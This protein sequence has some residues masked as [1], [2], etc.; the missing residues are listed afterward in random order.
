MGRLEDD[1]KGARAKLN[2]DPAIEDFAEFARKFV[3]NILHGGMRPIE[4]LGL[5][6]ATLEKYYAAAVKQYQSGQF[7]GAIKVLRVICTLCPSEFKFA[8]ALAA[9]NHRAQKW[10]E[11]VAG[12]QA[13]SLADPTDPLPYYHTADCM[14]KLGYNAA[15]AESLRIA[16]ENCTAGQAHA[17]I[18]DRAVLALKSLE[19]ARASAAAAEKNDKKPAKKAA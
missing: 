7:E 19:Q 8:F 18:K 9:C 1:I 3:K 12:Y 11:A 4:A 13:A 16:I 15:A 14:V 17:A 6:P 2:A 5:K 10:A